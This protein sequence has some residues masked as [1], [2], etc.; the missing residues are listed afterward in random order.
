MVWGAP[1]SRSS[2]GRSAV[3]T[4]S[5]TRPRSASTT[6]ACSSAAAVP[7]VTTTTA[8]RPVA[9]PIPSAVNPADRSSRRTCS[10][11]RGSAATARASGVERDPGHTTAWAHAGPHP[12]VDQGGGEGGLAV[13]IAGG[14]GP[15]GT[16]IG[17]LLCRP[18][19]LARRHRGRTPSRVGGGPRWCWP[20]ASPRPAGSGAASTDDL[21]ADHELVAGRPARPRRLRRRARRPG[22][23]G[24]A[25][26]GAAGGR[27][28]YLG[29]SMGA[30]FC[31]HLALA[32]PDLVRRLVLVSGTAGIDDAGE[33][34]RAPARP[35]RPWPTGSTRRTAGRPTTRSP[36]SSTAGWPTR[37]SA[38][39][40]RRGQR[41]RRAVRNTRGGPRLEPPPGRHGHPGAAVGPPGRA[42]PAGAGGHRRRDAKFTDLGRRLVGGHR[43]ATPRLVVVD[44]ADH[45]PHLQRPDAVAAA[46]RAFLGR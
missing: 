27:A 46:V 35:T 25:L 22:G 1:T 8:G 43:P 14:G 36:R 19:A 41:R 7:L 31:L 39:C 33:R 2:G 6:A 10:A 11:S 15:L 37:C 38:R 45:A 44:G 21:A 23:R 17:H 24:A 40:R 29:Y 13:G 26:L 5:G 9:I 30:R 3:Q 34:G 32:R 12:L 28:D 20:T 4:S 18:T 16:L 42:R